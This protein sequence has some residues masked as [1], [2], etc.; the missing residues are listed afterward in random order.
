M[1]DI[2]VRIPTLPTRGGDVLATEHL[3]TTGGGYNAMSSWSRQGPR[4]VY[5]GRLGTGP[6]SSIARGALGSDGIAEPI[7]ADSALDAG[8]CVAMVD[9]AGERTFVT[10]SG[11]EASLRA[12]DLGSLDVRVGDYVLVSGYNVMDES[13]DETIL[14]WI[15]SL[16][17]GVVV[18]FDPSNRVSDIP[19]DNLA[20]ILQRADWVLCNEIEAS[21]LTGVSMLEESVNQLALRAG[22]RGVVVRSGADGC[23]LVSAAHRATH[24]GAFE[25][26]VV[27][28]NGAGDTHSG[29]FLAELARGTGEVEAARR[30]NAAAALAIAVLGPASCPP[31]DV[32]TAMLA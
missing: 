14:G 3:T 17:D 11:A 9:D 27:D 21:R 30:G 2:V 19:S 31:R 12:S 15:G 7:Q 25:T 10:S 23:C 22:R 32:I 29:V 20:R 16:S 8:F 18:A 24:I 26:R 6:F 4:A 5:A 1:I 13:Q 28:T